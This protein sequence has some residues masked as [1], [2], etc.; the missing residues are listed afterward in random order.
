MKWLKKGVICSHHTKATQF[1]SKTAKVYYEKPIT[2]ADNLTIQE[3][4]MC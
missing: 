3:T 1:E 4:K 2:N